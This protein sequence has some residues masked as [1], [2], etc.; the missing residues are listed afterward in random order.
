MTNPATLFG[1]LIA[2]LCVRR[3]IPGT[4]PPAPRSLLLSYQSPRKVPVTGQA[5]TRVLCVPYVT[6]N[7]RQA[8]V[9]PPVTPSL[10]SFTLLSVT[11]PYDYC[12]IAGGLADPSTFNTPL[13]EGAPLYGRHDALAQASAP[14]SQCA[15][16]SQALSFA[17]RIRTCEGVV[18]Q[19]ACAARWLQASPTVVCR[20]SPSAK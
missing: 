19:A 8:G 13:S 12:P 17:L 20:A 2:L 4:Y 6:N 18:P 16:G 5:R 10:G 3:S 9:V 14:V 11:L 15:R 7:G 1:L